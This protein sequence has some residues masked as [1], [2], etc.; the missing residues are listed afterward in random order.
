VKKKKTK[1]CKYVKRQD[2]NANIGSAD[3]WTVQDKMGRK[4]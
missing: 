2:M 3:M 4:C 1:I